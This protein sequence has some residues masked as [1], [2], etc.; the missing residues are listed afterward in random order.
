MTDDERAVLDKL[1]EAAS[2]FGL[3][4]EVHASDLPEFVFAIHAA[5]NIVLARQSYLHYWK[6]AHEHH[7]D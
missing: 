4:P 1:G 5:Q 7:T 6:N 3:L 2:A